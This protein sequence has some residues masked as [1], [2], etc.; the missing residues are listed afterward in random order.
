M[1]VRPKDPRGSR[2]LQ[3]VVGVVDRYHVTSSMFDRT[4]AAAR[5][6]E[7]WA[8]ARLYEDLKQPVLGYV[9]LRGAADPD[10]VTSEV[11]LCVFRDLDRFEGDE[12]DFRAWV[13]TIAHR[14]VLDAWRKRSRRPRQARL[15]AG[16]DVEGGDTQDEALARLGR[17]EIEHLLEQ[18]TP[19]QRDVIL[20]RVLADL[21]LERV[22]EVT[23]R[24]VGAVKAL[25]HR[26]L[27]ALR[28][29]IETPP[30]SEPSRHAI[31]G[32]R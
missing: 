13:F 15:G 32:M 7:P 31:W 4:L 16:V 30:A 18:L 6:G 2:S 23:G 24:S 28:R 27:G 1:A 8:C 12:D 17:G 10:D 21:P 20:L 14:R 22:A 11:F 3:V 9:R 5:D 26:A 25:Q 19:E 29:A